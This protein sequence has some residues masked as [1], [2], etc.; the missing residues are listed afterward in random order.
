MPRAGCWRSPG[1]TSGYKDNDV[2]TL[3][4][5]AYLRDVCGDLNLPSSSCTVEVSAVE[6]IRLAT[7]RAVPLVLIAAELIINA[8][9]YAHP[10]RGKGKIRVALARRDDG[11]LVRSIDRALIGPDRQAE[12]DKLGCDMPDDL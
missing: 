5:G 9:K 2:A 8:V 12:A 11:Y 6:G 7:D 10:N 3:D 1:H 4:I